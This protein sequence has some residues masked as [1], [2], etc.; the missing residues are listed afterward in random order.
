MTYEGLTE[1]YKMC[2]Y[3]NFVK[4]NFSNAYFHL[5]IYEHDKILIKF[6]LG[7][8]F[9]QCKT[10]SFGGKTFPKLYC[11][12]VKPLI[13]F[14]KNLGIVKQIV[15]YNFFI[16]DFISEYQTRMKEKKNIRISQYL[17]E[18]LIL[19]ENEQFLYQFKLF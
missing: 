9:C 6:T 1:M 11:D 4:Y 13:N 16:R 15:K 3:P 12:L 17:D 14:L 5:G 2:R 7:S 10:V 8:T 18:F 19:H